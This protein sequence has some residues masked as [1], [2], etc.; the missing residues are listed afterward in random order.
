MKRF[1]IACLTI[2]LLAPH[3]L[4]AVSIEDFDPDFILSD[5]ELTYWQS[6]DLGAIERFL[7]SKGGYISTL[8][9]ED[10]DGVR[11][12][13]PEIIY[14]TARKYKINPKYII[15]KLQKEQSLVTDKTPTQ[16]QLDW[17]TGYG[18]CDSCSMDDERIQKFKGF[19]NQVD[20]SAGI[21]R[22]YY[23]NVS[24]QSFIKRPGTTYSISGESVRP[25][26][27][28]TAFLYTYTP[29]IQGNRNFWL[30]WNTWFESRFPN[31][32][33]IKG[34]TNPE[35]YLLENGEKRP[36]KNYTALITRF[37]P[38]FVVTVPDAELADYPVGSSIA[39]PNYAVLKNGSKYYLLDFD[40]IRPFASEA[41]VKDLG[42][43]PAEIIDV[44]NTD[45][46]GYALGT[47]ITAN[48]D[49]LGEVVFIPREGIH[50]FIKES[51]AY[52]IFDERLVKINYP[53]LTPTTKDEAYLKQFTL[54]HHVTIKNGIIFGIDGFNSIYVMEDGVKRHITNP[55]VFV[56]MGY[57]WENIQWVSRYTG[58]AIP[59]GDPLDSA[60]NR[61]MDDSDA[62]EFDSTKVDTNNITADYIVDDSTS[63]SDT[64]IE[65]T[66]DSSDPLSYFVRTPA[67][68][69]TYVGPRFTTDIESYLVYDMQ[70]EQIVAGKNIDF[71]RQP[72]SLQKVLTAYLLT[73]QGLS[74][75]KI[76]T[77]D[78]ARHKALY[79]RYRIV[80][81]EQIRNRNLLDAFL[82]S[83]LNTPGRMLVDRT[84]GDETTFITDMNTLLS[85][86]GLYHSSV[87][88]VTGERVA[89]QTTARDYLTIFKHG[90]ENDLV[91]EYL[92][93]RSYEYTAA[94]DKDGY[95]DHFDTHSNKLLQKTNLPYTIHASKTGFLWEAGG[96]LAM[97]VTRN[98]D[99]KEFIIITLGNPNFSD[100][101]TAVDNFARWAIS[102]F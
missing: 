22:W 6:M 90:I 4:F 61:I 74:T 45:I 92:S 84:V 86:W 21:M 64:S 1:F 31:G 67:D 35:I 43:N 71:V 15:V 49:P 95:P 19:G 41:V 16:K 97:H 82:V 42:Y 30:L 34:E 68:E 76:T 10:T 72:A 100:H 18:V 40:T 32:T 66:T 81:G 87:V 44:T 26:T 63:N 27:L 17:A 101:F 80:A 25:D 8:T 99:G 28:A 46:A 20:Y 23:D 93:K 55:A 53:H 36:F 12:P 3:G 79:H 24:D 94:L 2:S 73:Q 13:V 85:D 62:A 91:N 11:K 88:D 83:S 75:T 70:T 58:A 65:Q 9:I 29:H 33:L 102:T 60:P 54:G 77:Y 38:K 37:D 69:L 51:V 56:G 89:N 14:D 52:P 78:P 96:N 50:F 48:Y 47:T 98:T 39:L 57:K 5:D 59:T 7:K